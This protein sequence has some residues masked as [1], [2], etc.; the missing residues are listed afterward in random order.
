MSFRNLKKN[1]TALLLSS[2]CVYTFSYGQFPRK[3]LIEEFTSA[4][5][6]PCVRAGVYL[7][8]VLDENK[9]KVFSI[10]YHLNI[11]FPGDPMHLANKEETNRAAAKYNVPSLPD[12]RVDGNI[13][14]TPTQESEVRTAVANELKTTSPVEIKVNQSIRGNTIT[15]SVF[16][17][18]GANWS[19]TGSYKIFTTI[20]QRSLHYD[21]PLN[22]SN[23]E[24]DFND[25]FVKVLPNVAG[26]VFTIKR[27]ET[28]TFVYQHTNTSSFWDIN[29]FYS[30]AHIQSDD[31]N[32][33]I[34]CGDSEMPIRTVEA[35][36]AEGFSIYPNPV[37][38]N[39]NLSFN[40]GQNYQAELKLYN[41]IGELVLHKKNI[42]FLKGENNLSVDVASLLTGEY[43][44]VLSTNENKIIKSTTFK[45]S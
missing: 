19:G 6:V 18:A 33:V 14:V 27:N 11:P 28:K 41:V 44:C 10:R 42:E 45:K 15:D 17:T 12:M 9:G 13:T 4:T 16:V 24:K 1:L 38:Q 32:Q 43:V 35:E 36:L 20:V 40:I 8:K 25:V 2:L 31:D 3:V 5:C 37:T 7:N 29:E 22:N 26:D 23:G 34:Q 21:K 39:L 30:I